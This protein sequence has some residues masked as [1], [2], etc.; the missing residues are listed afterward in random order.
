MEITL[1]L[2]NKTLYIP[3]EFEEFIEKMNEALEVVDQDP[4]DPKDYLRKIFE[5][6]LE[7]CDL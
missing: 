4:I 6:A 2:E 3:D 7:D 1:D 5:E